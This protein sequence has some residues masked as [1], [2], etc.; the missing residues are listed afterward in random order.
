MTAKID[1]EDVEPTYTGPRRIAPDGANHVQEVLKTGDFEAQ[2]TWV[3]GLDMK[4]SFTTNAT[5]SKLTVEIG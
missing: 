5:E 2:V 4:R 1:G 3:I